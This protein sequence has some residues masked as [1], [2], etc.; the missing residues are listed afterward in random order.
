MDSFDNYVRQC[1]RQEPFSLPED[2]AG[3]VFAACAS[4]QEKTVTIRSRQNL[5]RWIAGAAAAL[6]I[7]VA[8]PNVSPTAAAAME[9]IPVL[10]TVVKVITFRN[11]VYDDDH[12]H[13]DVAVPRLEE[14]GSAAASV[15][16]DVQKYTDR[17]IEQFKADCADAGEGYAGLDVSYQVVSDTDSWFTLRV[18]AVETQASGYEFS[19][20]YNI[21]KTTDQVVHLDGLFAPGSDWQTVLTDEVS[22]Q[23]TEQMADP[24][25]GKDYFPEEFKGVTAD[26]NYYFDA[27]GNLVLVFDE[28]EIAPGSMGAPEF[29]IA[30]SV[31]QQLLK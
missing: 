6:A 17:L 10:G 28:Y 22:R 2:Y 8:V 19:K 15:N 5:R 11:Y 24:A 20:V 29:T 26:R 13:A 21:D 30:K 31:Y 27:D 25:S 9:N 12:S 18:D 1:A 23:M 4:L 16:Q 3:R 7:F 14:Q